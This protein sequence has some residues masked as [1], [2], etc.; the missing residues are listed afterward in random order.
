MAVKP[1]SFPLNAVAGRCSSHLRRCDGG[2]KSN[3]FDPDGH[4]RILIYRNQH[5]VPL[6]TVAHLRAILTF[7]LT[8]NTL[9]FFCLVPDSK[10]Q[11]CPGGQNGTNCYLRSPTRSAALLLLL[12]LILVATHRLN[13]HTVHVC[14]DLELT[15]LFREPELTRPQRTYCDLRLL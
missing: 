11:F 10:V 7:S 1:P 12:K 15:W 9:A 2:F 3:L 8:L 5:T 13:L 4:S 14:S 6:I